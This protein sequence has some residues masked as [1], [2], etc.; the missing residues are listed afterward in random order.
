MK[1]DTGQKRTKYITR[2]RSKNR[3]EERLHYNTHILSFPCHIACKNLLLSNYVIYENTVKN[4]QLCL[5]K[6]NTK[7]IG[8]RIKEKTQRKSVHTF[9]NILERVIFISRLYFYKSYPTDES[10]DSI[11]N[12]ALIGLYILYKLPMNTNLKL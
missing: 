5:N 1:E 4:K 11:S 3:R 8:L 10:A 12:F 6:N 2:Q 7:Q 9:S